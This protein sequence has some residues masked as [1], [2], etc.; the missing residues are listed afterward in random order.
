MA[1]G[2]PD[3][4]Q[5]SAGLSAQ[6]LVS[7]I[8]PVV[9]PDAVSQL[10][11]AFRKGAIGMADIQDRIGA[12]AM[13]QK[14]AHIEQLQEYVSPEAIQSRMG[15]IGAAGAQAE[16]QTAQARAGTGLVQPLAESSLADI[17]QHNAMRLSGDAV[18][19]YTSINPPIYKID[20]NGNPTSEYD[21]AA[22]N[23]EGAE[24]M[25]AMG[26][27]DYA[28]QKLQGTWS[29][30]YDE[31]LKQ[32]RK[33]FINANGENVTPGSDRWK[34]YNDLRDQAF[35]RLW[36]RPDTSPHFDPAAG[37]GDST[38]P[39]DA[40]LSGPMGGQGS[41]VT[42]IAPAAVPTAPTV[43]TSQ[44]R[45]GIIAGMKA[46]G[47]DED[48]ATRFVAR[49]T[50]ADV[51][52]L[53]QQYGTPVPTIAPSDVTGVPA[54]VPST[55][56]TVTP[57]PVPGSTS[58]S[59][60]SF[61]AG[62]TA[63]FQAKAAAKSALEELP[64]VKAFS[65]AKPLYIGFADAANATAK[66]PPSKVTDLALAEAYTKLFDPTARITEFKYDELKNAI[67]WLEKFKDLPAII[68]REHTFPKAVRQEIIDSGMQNINLREK[69]LQPR[70][71]WA[72]DQ[73]PNILDDEQKQILA[74]VPFSKRYGV[75]AGAVPKAD[76]TTLP[77]GKRVRWIPSP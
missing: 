46:A 49:A 75:E 53:T 35:E 24:I 43:D 28:Q 15:Q 57:S 67:P 25:R 10:V 74:G 39:Q 16:L 21:Y 5:L 54:A 32:N 14:R 71:K 66:A 19:A 69:A 64:D 42:P 1:A 73:S 6:Q 51:A 47:I 65:T 48:Q 18:K 77:S 55:A 17:V 29:E 41:L 59:F 70:F 26:M 27:R 23:R 22:M 52:K 63:D 31:Q 30:Y 76:L 72:Q 13:A 3:A 12:E 56:P 20:A 36:K 37:E 61:P 2:A 68:A 11:D 33:A 34:Y 7:P 44:A 62:P 60:A 40:P 50:S 9:T 4:P 58:P 8:T 38:P 45:A